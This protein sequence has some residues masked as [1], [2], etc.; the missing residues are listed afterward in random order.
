MVALPEVARTSASRIR[1]DVVLPAPLGPR[2]PVTRPGS[3]R[4]VKSSTARTAPNV[5]VTPRNSRRCPSGIVILSSSS[6]FVGRCLHPAR[7]ARAG[8]VRAGGA[9]T[10]GAGNVASVSDAAEPTVLVRT[11]RGVGHLTLNRP[12]AINALDLGM[13]QT[14]SAA[15]DRWEHDADIEVVLLDGAGERGLCAGGDG[16]FASGSSPAGSTRP[17]TSSAPSTP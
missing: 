15:L 4:A 12:R 10:D 7:S 17:R 14:I 13:I 9:E 3:T 6:A 5:F 16:A 1:N 8:R 2:K 11:V